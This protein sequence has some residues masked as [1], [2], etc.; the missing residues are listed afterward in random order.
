MPS[1]RVTDLINA[2]SANVKSRVI[3][4]RPGE[5]IHEELSKSG[6]Y[7]KTIHPRIKIVS[8]TTKS[9]NQLLNHYEKQRYIKGN[10]LNACY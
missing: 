8:E 6:K 7:Y 10:E 2:M 3:G 5:K 4:V 1:F 9:K